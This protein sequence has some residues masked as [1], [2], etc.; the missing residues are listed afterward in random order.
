MGSRAESGSTDW[1]EVLAWISL[2]VK[3]SYFHAGKSSSGWETLIERNN[4]LSSKQLG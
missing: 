2:E 4:T 1:G 3:I